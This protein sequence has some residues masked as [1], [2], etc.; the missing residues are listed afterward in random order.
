MN[1]NRAMNCPMPTLAQ[2]LKRPTVEQMTTLSRSSIYRLMKRGQFPQA[3][4]LGGGKA[5]AWRADEVAAWIE[6]RT[7]TAA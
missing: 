1:E 5:V 7:R 3:V 6:S 2:L 4:S